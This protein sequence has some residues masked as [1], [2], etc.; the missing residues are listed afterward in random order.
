MDLKRE[1]T[2]ALD[3][4][5]QTVVNPLLDGTKYLPQRVSPFNFGNYDDPEEI[6]I[7]DPDAAR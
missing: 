5:C 3:G 6:D 4:D 2:I 1:G 7:Y